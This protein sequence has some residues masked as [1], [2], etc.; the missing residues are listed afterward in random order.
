[1]K[2][3]Y[4]FDISF[5]HNSHKTGTGHINGTF[6]TH[7]SLSGCPSATQ[8]AQGIKKPKFDDL[9]VSVYSKNYISGEFF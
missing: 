4:F 1:M 6:L 9:S 7:R 5:T 8:A 3:E 2:Y